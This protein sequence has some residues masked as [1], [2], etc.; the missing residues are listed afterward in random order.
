MAVFRVE[1]NRNYT[2]MSNY[3]LRDTNLSLKAIGLLS[4]MLSLVDEWDYTT[5]GLAAICKEGVDAI[6]AALKELEV[7]GYLVRRQL[8]DERGRITDTEYIIYESPHTP[9]PS[10]APPDTENPDMDEPDTAAP[11]PTLPA[12][13]NIDQR[14]P[15]K[16]N[17]DESITEKSNPY[18]SNPT[19]PKAYQARR[20]AGYDGMG[21]E[22]AKEIVK[23]NID[24]DL[25][26]QEPKQDR[27]RLDEV[28]SLIAETLCSRKKTLVIAGDEY[29]AELVKEKLLKIDSMHIEYFFDC[30][31]QN[32]TYVRNIK[33][34][35][36]AA[37]FNAPS[38]IG[39]YY[40][41]LVQ[42]DQYGNGL[43]GK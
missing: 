13:L 39:S 32:T 41:A 42:H 11:Y 19:A 22:E 24:Y 23:E 36:L 37:L 16:R 10:T 15:E 26:I 3:H 2:V 28:V 17:P 25:L 18:P 40:S 38:T 34:Y 31:S 14:N 9:S 5:R 7:S 27:E 21:Y 35:M 20:D 8:R 43:R 6:G 12:Q 33:K 30:L 4:K 1:K 29:P